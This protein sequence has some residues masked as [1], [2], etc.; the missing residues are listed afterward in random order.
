MAAK[1]KKILV[2]FPSFYLL[3]FLIFNH[4]VVLGE[5]K[6]RMVNMVYRH[7]DRSPTTTF[8]LDKN[9][10]YWPQG[11]GQLTRLGMLQEYKLGKFIKKRYI[12]DNELLNKTMYLKDEVYCRSTDTD[13]TIMSAQAQMNGLYPPH[14]N[15][16]WRPHVE[17][18]PIPVHV[19]SLKNDKL[20][21]G[22]N[23]PRYEELMEKSYSSQE[24][25]DIKLK[26]QDFYKG[27]RVQTGLN[28]SLKFRNLYS[29]HDNLFCS[30][31]HNLTLPSWANTTVMSVLKNISN[32]EMYLLTSSK[33]MAKLQYGLLLGEMIKHMQGFVNHEKGIKKA[34]IYSAHDTTISGMLAVLGLFDR[35]SP[36]YSSAVM[37]E[38]YSSDNG[39]DQSVRIFYRFGQSDKP[40][41]LTLEGCDAD[42]PLNDFIE[43]TKDSIPKD[44]DAEC[45]AK[46]KMCFKS[47]VYKS[48]LA[49]FAGTLVI[50]ILLSFCLCCCW[51]KR[52]R[53]RMQATRVNF[54]DGL[55][56]DA[57]LLHNQDYDSE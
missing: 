41:Q 49:A 53:S 19:E 9:L 57:S 44:R 37:L 35:I 22:S 31:S 11:L 43:L 4:N 56:K 27:L 13:R 18:Q 5:K 17:W 46:E 28:D 39:N 12:D 3:I 26:Y 25:K 51:C 6:L 16:I 10:K 38:L 24:Y 15:Q 47:I 50:L 36:P 23:C 42:C 1:Q 34:Y 14:G 48:F 32:F 45:G 54:D 33:E 2:F 52:R 21:R 8:P 55:L 7:G 29:V 20:L 40:R 30:Q